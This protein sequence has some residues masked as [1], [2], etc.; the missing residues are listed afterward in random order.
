[1][2][3]IVKV[4]GEVNSVPS[5]KA[6]IITR[7]DKGE[8]EITVK[9]TTK[10]TDMKINNKGYKNELSLIAL[11]YQKLVLGW[12]RVQASTLLFLSI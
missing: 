9:K 5:K 2:I 1:M 10:E 4:L 6:A 11:E 8:N 3:D 12:W 7:L